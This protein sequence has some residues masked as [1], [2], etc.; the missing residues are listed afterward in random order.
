MTTDDIVSLIRT[1]EGQTIEFKKSYESVT[2]DVYETV[3]SFSNSDGGH[4][5][6]GVLD[7]GTINGIREDRVEAEK[8]DFVTTVNNAMKLHPPLYLCPE[9]YSIEGKTILYV[10][11]P[12]AA[13]VCR[14]RGRVFDR[15]N[16]SDIDIT[17]NEELMYRLYAR[18]SGNYFVNKVY[19][20]F[21]VSDLDTGAI[22]HARQMTRV[23]S[24]AHPWLSMNDE[25]LLRS[26]DL[27]LEDTATRQEGL[28]LAAVLLFGRRSTIMSVLPQHKTDA[29]YRIE[30]MD[31]YDDRDVIVANLLESYDRL[32][33]F[34]RKHL[35]DPFVLEGVQSVSARDAILREI[36]SNMLEHRDF[37]SG[38]VAK[39]I[40]ERDR[41][42][43]ENSNQPHGFGRLKL[44]TLQPFS[45]NPPISKVF[46]EIGLADELGSGMRNTY[47]YTKLYSGGT[48]DFE[49]GDVFRAT[50]PLNS[51]ATERVGPVNVRSTPH[52]NPHDNPHDEAR[53]EQILKFCAVPRNRTEI[54]EYLDIKDRSYFQ[55]KILKPL[56]DSGDLC[57]T[58]PDKPQSKNQRYVAKLNRDLKK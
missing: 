44:D 34:G 8:K 27:I 40:I 41:I 38:F 50:I 42:Y 45:K 12:K 9:A 56:L 28:T 58:L 7:D 57:L 51:T 33:E 1:G 52:D 20:A 47:K 36:I 18:K 6:L 5:F 55:K 14:C 19:P 53:T 49:E 43:T 15:N 3:C 10:Y 25:Q 16:D 31:R 11:V 23:R 54:Q 24:D 46:R 48:P 39:L 22:E 30:N 2:K 29:I 26:A 37:S 4:I 13:Y 35:N 17:D 32:M 21:A